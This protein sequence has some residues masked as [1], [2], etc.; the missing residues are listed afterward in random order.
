MSLPDVNAMECSI[1]KVTVHRALGLTS[2]PDAAAALTALG[3]AMGALGCTMTTDDLIAGTTCPV[4]AGPVLSA[5]TAGLAMPDD[6][7]T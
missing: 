6:A 2:N 4:P 1:T 5:F 3:G 7:T